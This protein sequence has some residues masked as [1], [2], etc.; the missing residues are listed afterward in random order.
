MLSRKDYIGL[1]NAIATG[2]VEGKFIDALCQ[3]LRTDNPRFN[4]EK[5]EDYIQRMVADKKK[6]AE[7]VA[8]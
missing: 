3:F 1:C 2:V 5:F 8:F 6:E 7:S 4:R